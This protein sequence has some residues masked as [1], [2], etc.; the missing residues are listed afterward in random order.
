MVREK[1]QAWRVTERFMREA[2][3]NPSETQVDFREMLLTKNA[4]IAS[5]DKTDIWHIEEAAS[6]LP[7][8]I[9]LIQEGEF[10]LP[11]KQIQLK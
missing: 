8:K 3:E 10:F 11:D 4:A 1:R 7:T 9:A 6:K 5:F 2:G